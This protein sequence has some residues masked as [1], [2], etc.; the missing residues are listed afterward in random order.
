M[1]ESKYIKDKIEESKRCV[2]WGT[3]DW[4]ISFD[5]DEVCCLLYYSAVLN[6]LC[7]TDTLKVIHQFLMQKKQP[8]NTESQH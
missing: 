7:L 2:L 5:V 8:S 1:I 3:S 4:I 6:Q